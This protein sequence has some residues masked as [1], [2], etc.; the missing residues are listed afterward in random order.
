MTEDEFRQL[1][2]D[3]RKALARQKRERIIIAVI[4]G[5]CGG[6]VPLLCRILQDLFN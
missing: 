5:V 6:L 2:K 1:E 4:G 3:V